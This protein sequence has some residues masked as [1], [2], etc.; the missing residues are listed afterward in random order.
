VTGEEKRHN[1]RIHKPESKVPFGE[2]A[3]AFRAS[4]A[5]RGVM[6]CEARWAGVVPV[7]PAGLDP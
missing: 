5:K 6:T 1:G 2:C 4:W 3:K 7:G